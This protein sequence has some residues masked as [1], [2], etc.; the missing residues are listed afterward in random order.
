[1]PRM[2]DDYKSKVGARLSRS[3]TWKRSPVTI[4]LK[5]LSHELD[6]TFVTKR[7]DLGLKK[8]RDCFFYMSLGI[9]RAIIIFLPVNGSLH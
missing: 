6:W 5:G 7:I 3:W 2:R 1:M 9:Y 8:R 4:T